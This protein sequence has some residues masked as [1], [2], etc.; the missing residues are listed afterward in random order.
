MWSPTV[1]TCPPTDTTTREYGGIEYGGLPVKL[2]RVHLMNQTR[3]DRA[4]PTRAWTAPRGCWF[5][6]WQ[7]MTTTQAGH[8]TPG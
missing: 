5:D 3:P 7:Y 2:A 8:W 1:P 6:T 4:S